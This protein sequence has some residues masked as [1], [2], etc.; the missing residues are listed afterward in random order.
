M[1]SW[2]VAEGQFRMETHYGD[3]AVPCLRHRPA[4]L[5]AMLENAVSARP[6]S[7][8]LVC[9]DFRCTWQELHTLSQAF[10][11]GMVARGIKPGDRV[12]LFLGNRP[13]FVITLYAIMRIG[14]VAV[15]VGIRE[16]APGLA[17]IVEQ[18]GASLILHEASLAHLLPQG[19][20]AVAIGETDTRTFIAS[21]A[22][23][24]TPAPIHPPQDDDAALIMYTSGTTGRP[25][26]AISSH[27]ALTHMSA[28]Y[29]TC[30]KLSEQDRSICIVPL[31]HITGITAE[32]CAMAYAQA[33]LIIVPE[34]KADL[35]LALAEQEG[36]THT[37]MVPAMYNLILDRVDLS[38]FDLSAWR[39]G[40]FGGSPMPIPTIRQL[41]GQLPLL[42]LM[43]V[44]GA[45]E[46]SGAATIMPHDYVEERSGS[47]GLAVPG[48][49]IRIVDDTGNDLPAG[50]TGELWI[51]GPT[52]TPGYWRNT[53]ATAINLIDGFWR[54]G[55]LGFLDQDGFVHV[56][57][58]L[59]D[60]INRGGYK[61]FTAEVES[62]LME[63]PAVLE[64]AVIAKPCAIL[65]ERVH[66]FI[67]L[68]EDT[69]TVSQH[70]LTEYCSTRM[71]DYKQPESYTI[72]HVPLPR[73]L[74]GKV[75]KTELRQMLA[76]RAS[77]AAF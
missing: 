39:I 7:E 65:G 28:T 10:A 62:I 48:T 26:G 37:L 34:F 74:N 18:S 22:D 61:I 21:F 36:M 70:E 73:N 59:K 14:A 3:H 53:E 33:C 72:G 8:A 17:Y 51:S 60:M 57:D 46:I 69:G 25:K 31:S 47:V 4:S 6:N 24:Q 20:D 42:Q 13:E 16:Q 23:P 68:S 38:Q 45:T 5:Y 30:M 58:R 44:Y 67:T 71:T 55:D 2:P 32:L 27:L 9:G 1:P 40:A 54:S 11:T 15:P 49:T 41:K 12:V 64:A 75:V 63:H 35:F 52:I 77:P 29:A 76:L 19:T 56:L 50:E 43:N 66:A